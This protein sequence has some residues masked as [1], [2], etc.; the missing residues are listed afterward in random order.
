MVTRRTAIVVHYMVGMRMAGNSA[1][2]TV[3]AED[4]LI[5]ALRIQHENPAA[6]MTYVRKQNERVDRHPHRGV[7][8]K[9]E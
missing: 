3:E 5:A 1:S 8:D 4:V 9:S 7:S 2:V 6:V